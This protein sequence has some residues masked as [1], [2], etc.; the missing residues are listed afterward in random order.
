ML[1]SHEEELRQHL[2]EG[3]ARALEA[4]GAAGVAAVRD[5][6]AHGYGKPIRR[7]GALMDSIAWA[8]DAGRVAVGTNL[9][10]AEPVHN[11][12][13]CLAGRPFL[14]DGLARG[15]EE[16]VRRGG[17]ALAEAMG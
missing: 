8:A 6:M 16:I 13:R 1:T 12:T 11:G 17:E 9:P 14:T 7:T 10:Y 4:M 15:A 5:M 3:V 2:A